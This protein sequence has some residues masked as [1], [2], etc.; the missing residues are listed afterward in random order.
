[1]DRSD[2]SGFAPRA[3]DRRAAGDPLPPVPP[4][5]LAGLSS[6]TEVRPDFASHPAASERLCSTVVA[7]PSWKRCQSRWD[8]PP[9][10]SFHQLLLGP[11]KSHGSAHFPSPPNQRVAQ[12]LPLPPNLRV[13]L[14][15][16]L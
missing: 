14:R 12:I 11:A 2:P 4:A 15:V 6:S 3:L 5:A 9:H 8:R 1:L 16:R 7:Y 10:C 13:R